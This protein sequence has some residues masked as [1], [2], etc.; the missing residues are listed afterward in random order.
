MNG[1]GSATAVTL[2]DPPSPEHSDNDDGEYVEVPQQPKS[3][4]TKARLMIIH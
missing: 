3:N 4:S 1:S 2:A